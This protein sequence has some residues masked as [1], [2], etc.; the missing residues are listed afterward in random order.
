MHL[1]AALATA[2][3]V[4]LQYVMILMVLSCA[5]LLANTQMW[6]THQAIHQ[7]LTPTLPCCY[8]SSNLDVIYS[9]LS[10]ASNPQAISDGLSLAWEDLAQQLQQQRTSVDTG[11]SP[12]INQP[13]DSS[14]GGSTDT[15]RKLLDSY[16]TK[17]GPLVQKALKALDE[18]LSPDPGYQQAA[19]GE[20]NL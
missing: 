1:A 19:A 2:S 15:P 6:Q 11:S 7:P 8:C 16:T 10:N 18:A 20:P 14:S 5:M 3:A 13:G 9:V 4:N 17:F 12:G